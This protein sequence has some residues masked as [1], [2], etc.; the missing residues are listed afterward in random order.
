M[1]VT[2][3]NNFCTAA[4]NVDFLIFIWPL[5]NRNLPS[6]F[7][8]VCCFFLVLFPFLQSVLSFRFK[9][10]SKHFEAIFKTATIS[11]HLRHCSCF[12]VLIF[13]S[14]LFHSSLLLPTVNSA[15]MVAFATSSPL[16]LSK[17][18]RV[19]AA[20][21]AGFGPTCSASSPDNHDARISRR[22]LIAAAVGAIAAA[23]VST[24]NPAYAGPFG[25]PSL[26]D[27][28]VP[29]LSSVGS[30]AVNKANDLGDDLQSTSADLQ[31]K[32]QERKS[33]SRAVKENIPSDDVGKSVVK[34]VK[35]A[36]EDGKSYISEKAPSD[37]V[38]KTATASIE[39]T[40]KGAHEDLVENFDYNYDKKL[41]NPEESGI[42][43]ETKDLME[44][45]AGVGDDKRVK[46]VI[47]EAVD[48]MK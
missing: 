33:V 32:M 11:F 45:S 48:I 23:A 4:Q 1:P 8:G 34:S 20:R 24:Y 30:S 42:D 15:T 44:K 18:G 17:Q 2:S 35:D 19:S 7:V 28:S 41:K 40:A 21:S 16:V 5:L 9:P 10:V 37:D 38:G 27:F 13:V 3:G 39:N 26:R 46:S 25:L 31:K 43:L 6:L 29:D 22:G 14:R 47:D 36:V 12:R